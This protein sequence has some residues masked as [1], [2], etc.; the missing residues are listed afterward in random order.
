MKKLF[1]LSVCMTAT[2]LSF[3]QVK[4]GVQLGASYANASN[5]VTDPTNNVKSTIETNSHLGFLGGAVGHIPIVKSLVFRPELNFVQKNYSM[6]MIFA[7]L[8]ATATADFVMNYIE[9]PAHLVYDFPTG[10]GNTFV[11]LGPSLTMGLSGKLKS[12]GNSVDVKFDGKT[13]A[14]GDNNLH[15]K[16]W[17][18]GISFIAGQQFSNGLYTTLGYNLGLSNT[19]PDPKYSSYKTN[20]ISLK[21]GYMFDLTKKAVK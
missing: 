17:D 15:M 13:N 14:N 12:G 5:K 7:D 3:S 9:L 18:A 4:L 2:I 10:S 1:I 21:V 6:G 8:G 19:D 16:Q 20:F 11:G